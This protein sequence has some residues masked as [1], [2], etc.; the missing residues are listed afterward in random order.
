MNSTVMPSLIPEATNHQLLAV[1]KQGKI[2]FKIAMNS[3]GCK[4]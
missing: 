3:N 1:V 4:H 2:S